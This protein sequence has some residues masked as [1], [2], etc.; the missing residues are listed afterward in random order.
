[1]KAIKKIFLNSLHPKKNLA[2]LR[3]L[4]E[5]LHQLL[6]NLPFRRNYAGKSLLDKK[7]F[8]QSTQRRKDIKEYE[9]YKKKILKLFAL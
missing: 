1:M 7:N 5:I 4:R 2:A 6:Y 8:S 9:A 3:S